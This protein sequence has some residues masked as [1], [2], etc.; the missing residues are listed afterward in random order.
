MWRLAVLIGVLALTAACTRQPPAERPDAGLRPVAPAAG[1]KLVWLP[2]DTSAQ[3]LC[4]V[5]TKQQWQDLFG[6]PVQRTANS[7]GCLLYS[8]PNA[9]QLSMVEMP[10][11]RTGK[12]AGRPALVGP[13]HPV[14]DIKVLLTD[15]DF[16][17]AHV[18]APPR[19]ALWILGGS[20]ECSTRCSTAWCRCLSTRARACFKGLSSEGC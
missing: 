12:I 1:D 2:R 19:P 17:R 13:G 14:D 4:Q 5:L 18:D 20:E 8:G 16:T 3:V 7:Y 6:R 10:V 9:I 15:T 11:Q